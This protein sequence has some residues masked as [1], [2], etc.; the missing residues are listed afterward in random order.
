MRSY[1]T[2]HVPTSSLDWLASAT[3]MHALHPSRLLDVR[4]MHSREHVR[5]EKLRDSAMH[6]RR[7]GRGGGSNESDTN[8]GATVWESGHVGGRVQEGRKGRL[9]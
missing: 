9:S 4:I 2:C 8:G 7:S 3:R 5:K 6:T 1:R